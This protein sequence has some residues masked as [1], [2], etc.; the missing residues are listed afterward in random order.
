[1]DGKRARVVSIPIGVDGSRIPPARNGGVAILSSGA[2]KSNERARGGT[3][4]DICSEICAGRADMCRINP[5]QC[6]RAQNGKVDID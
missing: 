3:Y 2:F 4:A 6:P 5:H 1:M